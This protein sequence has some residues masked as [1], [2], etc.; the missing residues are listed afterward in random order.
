MGVCGNMSLPLTVALTA[1]NIAQQLPR[2]T[3]NWISVLEMVSILFFLLPI[4]RLD[5]L[6]LAVALRV[7]L[8]S[9]GGFCDAMSKRLVDTWGTPHLERRETHHRQCPGCRV[10]RRGTGWTPRYPPRRPACG[11][12]RR[13][14]RWTHRWSRPRFWNGKRASESARRTGLVYTVLC[15]LSF[16]A[17]S[18]P[19]CG[20][21][22]CGR[23]WWAALCPARGAGSRSRGSCSRTFGCSVWAAMWGQTS[24]K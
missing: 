2:P 9:H 15:H 18:S 3:P 24:G 22:T 8:A 6:R 11:L 16:V 14:A 19:F 13:S 7:D 4:D 12:R 1:L 23:C 17:C 21:A 20:N 10:W 5:V